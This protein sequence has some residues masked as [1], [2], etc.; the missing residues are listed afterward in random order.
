[1]VKSVKFG[2]HFRTSAEQYLFGELFSLIRIKLEQRSQLIYIYMIRQAFSASRL[3]RKNSFIFLHNLFTLSGKNYF[4]ASRDALTSSTPSLRLSV[5]LVRYSER[6][7]KCREKIAR[8]KK[9]EW[10][11][12]GRW[13]RLRKAASPTNYARASGQIDS[14]VKRVRVQSI[15]QQQAVVAGRS[16]APLVAVGAG[17]FTLLLQELFLTRV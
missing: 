9:I 2:P 3:A 8:T 10:C 13:G 4:L 7:T 16:P 15:I 5:C 14:K 12:G 6:V 1:M 11:L 17:D